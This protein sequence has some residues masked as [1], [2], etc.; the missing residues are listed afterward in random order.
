[1]AGRNLIRNCS[2]KFR[3][4]QS[5]DSLLEAQYYAYDRVRYCSDCGEKVYLIHDEH[6]LF[7]AIEH[8]RCV[9]IPFD[10][11]NGKKQLDKPLLGAINFRK[12]V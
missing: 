6:E 8:N 3:C 2:W 10:I 12:S 1:M 11:T 5:W 9:A 7:L 4:S